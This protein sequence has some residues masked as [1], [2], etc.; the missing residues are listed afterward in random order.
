VHTRVLAQH[1]SPAVSVTLLKRAWAAVTAPGI[2]FCEIH[3]QAM[4]LPAPAHTASW[5]MQ[6]QQH[7]GRPQLPVAHRANQ[8]RLCR[9]QASPPA[10]DARASNSAAEQQLDSLD[11][12][13]GAGVCHV[14]GAAA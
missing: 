11:A 7:S 2:G 6:Q 13:L 4:M 3:Q 10:H 14:E 8:H 12:L 1:A 9:A 5:R